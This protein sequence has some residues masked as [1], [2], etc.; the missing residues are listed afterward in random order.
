MADL[1]RTSTMAESAASQGID[2]PPELSMDQGS[3]DDDAH[4]SHTTQPE[5][6][7]Q[8]PQTPGKREAP[9]EGGATPSAAK[10][11]DSTELASRSNVMANMEQFR[12]MQHCLYKHRKEWSQD[13][14]YGDADNWKMASSLR[15]WVDDLPDGPWDR[16]WHFEGPEFNRINPLDEDHQ[17]SETGS[18]KG[19]AEA[20][21]EKE[22]V[23]T[24]RLDRDEYD[25]TIDY[26]ARRERLRK[27]FE[28]EL[29]RLFLAEEI[30]TRRRAKTSKD[31]P[32]EVEA[33]STKLATPDIKR[34]KWEQFKNLSDVVEADTCVINILLGD[35]VAEDETEYF[36]TLQ[37]YVRRVE[38]K[39]IADVTPIDR[40]AGQKTSLPPAGS[41]AL[42]NRIRIHSIILRRILAKI[43]GAGVRGIGGEDDNSIVVV[44]PYKALLS[45]EDA[46]RDW[47]QNLEGKYATDPEVEE[48]EEED[49]DDNDDA[50]SGS[51]KTETGSVKADVSNDDKR[52]KGTSKE[53]RVEIEAKPRE[54]AEPTGGSETSTDEDDEDEDD[55]EDENGSKDEDANDSSAEENDDDLLQSRPALEHLKVLL[56]FMSSEVAPRRAYLNSDECKKVYYSDLWHIFQPGTEVITEEGRQAYR[57]LRVSSPFQHAIPS[58]LNFSAEEN[59]DTT[60]F[61]RPYHLKCV[62]IDFDGTDIGPVLQ[63]FYIKSFE[64]EREIHTLPVYPLRCHP[65][66]KDNFSSLEWKELASLPPAKRFRQK[67]LNR[68]DRFLQ[69]AGVRHMYYAGPTVTTGEEIESPVVVDCETA[70]GAEEIKEM[71][72]AP[73][74]QVLIAGEGITGGTDNEEEETD[75]CGERCCVGDFVYND[76]YIDRERTSDQ[77]ASLQRTNSPSKPVSLAI[78]PQSLAELRTSDGRFPAIVDEEKLIMSHRV[79][80]FIL[81]NRKWGKQ[82]FRVNNMELFT[83]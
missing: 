9:V 5:Q 35:P 68:G 8:P 72:W 18:E 15:S 59:R 81:R 29:D 45:C 76:G 82:D 32:E 14:D 34:V 73:K 30:E 6:T 78:L 61:K 54:K 16:T 69:L 63:D 62:Y 83:D 27:N 11:K 56:E 1:T 41:T 7:Q 37:G 39:I 47:M 40:A 43:V 50:T 71:D 20:E 24:T 2:T 28:W 42:P 52:A 46:M 10:A 57:I 25:A 26:G 75:S 58:R 79:F 77:L 12:R 3:T 17:C 22:K 67:L 31:E 21:P 44:A 65:L 64:G 55:D 80:G 13:V 60:S 36:A 19:K 70:L 53:T 49:E 51:W 4:S 48:V 38:R 23:M 66:R 33:D 74:L